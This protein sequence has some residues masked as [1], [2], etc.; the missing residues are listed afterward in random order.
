MG[1]DELTISR[2][3]DYSD[4]IFMVYRDGSV[5]DVKVEYGMVRPVFYLS[6]SVLYSQGSGTKSDPIRIFL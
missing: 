1:I 3:S 5:Y 4:L 2:A 6:S